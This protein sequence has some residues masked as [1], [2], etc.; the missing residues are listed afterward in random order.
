MKAVEPVVAI[1]SGGEGLCAFRGA[2]RV[3]AAHRLE[4]VREALAEV[5]RAADLGRHAVG[6]VAYGAASAFDS[7]LIASQPE[8]LPHA[9]FA[10]FDRPPLPI[11]PRVETEAL[12]LKWGPEVSE[13]EYARGIERI[14]EALADGKTY[15]VNYTQRFRTRFEGDALALF[16]RLYRAQPARY[17][18]YLD[19]GRFAVLCASPE[20][21]FETDGVTIATEPM[22]GTARRG[23]WLEEDEANR[24]ALRSSEKERAENVMIVDLMRSDFGR[25]AR[26][27]SVRVPALFEVT[28]L[29]A[30]W[31]MTSTVQAELREG[32]KL[33]DIFAAAFPPGS[34]TGAPKPRTMRIIE[35]LERS[36]RGVYCGAIGVVESGGRATFNV[37][38]RTVVVDRRTGMAECGLGSGITW[39]STAAAEH[40]EMLAKAE[41]LSRPRAEFDLLETM[42]LEQGRYFLLERHLE[43]LRR[44]AVYFGFA[45][46]E[47][48]VRV[49]LAGTAASLPDGPHRVRLRVSRSGEACVEASPVPPS[50]EWRARLAASPV[51]ESDPFLCNKTTNRRVYEAHRAGLGPNEEVLLWNRRGEVT[52]FTLGSLVYERRGRLHTPPRE[53]GLLD[54]TM[55]AELLERGVVTESALTVAE[56]PACAGLWHVNSLR[57]AI[58]AALSGYPNLPARPAPNVIR[59]HERL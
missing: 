48:R 17:A 16:W 32:V 38:I 7:A 45:L 55:R 51:D 37:A 44:S 46:D 39:G 24:D 40:A 26:T 30:V 12:E 58:P 56:L 5:R 28:G 35:A 57:G 47:E 59:I 50:P 3:V 34:V 22:K 1:W 21:F 43:R 49:R 31:Q 36:P 25:I 20:L 33:E 9:W 2:H 42:R 52:E 18:S 27:G 11:E 4:D 19:T 41:F 23:R 14:R 10:V 13:E 29:P 6:F 15:Q 8:G 53:C 54:G